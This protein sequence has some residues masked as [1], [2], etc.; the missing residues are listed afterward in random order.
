MPEHEGAWV[1]D[2]L[3][4]YTSENSALA[5]LR[6]QS[7]KFSRPGLFNDDFD[8]RVTLEYE[9]DINLAAT[10]VAERLW[11]VSA[12]LDV[13][14]A[15]NIFGELLRSLTV[16]EAQAVSNRDAMVE[17]IRSTVRDHLERDLPSQFPILSRQL[18]AF[19]AKMKV[20]CLSHSPLIQPMWASYADD[21]SGAVLHFG[22]RSEDSIFLNAR[23]VEYQGNN[24][25]LMDHDN[26]VDWLSGRQSIDDEKARELFLYTKSADW[27]YEQEWRLVA[28]EGVKPQ[29]EIEY[30]PF[31]ADDL[32]AVVFGTRASEVFRSQI[33][34]IVHEKFPGTQLK[35]LDRSD[36]ARTFNILD[37]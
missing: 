29:E 4:K 14:T 33:S 7:L 19:S 13:A 36:R 5:I 3:Y 21:L 9:V 16:Y 2:D 34:T 23:A 17:S 37:V 26:I 30:W 15:D 27:S 28:G 1:P 20:L 24:P 31:A 8:M 12:G 10:E 6:N 25:V 11:K 35:R 22:P 32:K 18:A